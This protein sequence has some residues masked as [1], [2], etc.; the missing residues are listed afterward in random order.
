MEKIVTKL[1][2]ASYFEPLKLKFIQIS[3]H[4]GYKILK[5]NTISD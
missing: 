1:K 3:F 5:N 4:N 2:H